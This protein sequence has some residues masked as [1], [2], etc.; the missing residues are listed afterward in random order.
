MDIEITACNFTVFF[1]KFNIKGNTGVV[2][3]RWN[4]TYTNRLQTISHVIEKKMLINTD[5]DSRKW[6]RS[7]KYIQ[8]P[9]RMKWCRFS[10]MWASKA[11]E[12][13]ACNMQVSSDYLCT[14][15]DSIRSIDVCVCVCVYER[16]SSSTFTCSPKKTHTFHLVWFPLMK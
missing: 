16:K 6:Q 1:F 2:W 3:T 15:F 9:Q 11:R 12:R 5:N 10:K 8:T 4:G 13:N 14:W 7:H